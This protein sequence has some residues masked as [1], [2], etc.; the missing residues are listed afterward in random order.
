MAEDLL[1]LL[2]SWARQRYVDAA[3][4]GAGGKGCVYVAT[5][6][7]LQRPVALKV[8]SPDLSGDRRERH[9]FKREILT[10][11]H[12]KHPNVVQFY[13]FSDT[14]DVMFYTMELLEGRTLQDVIQTDDLSI[15]EAVELVRQVCSGV[16]AIHGAGLF[17]RDLKPGNVVV[18]D[19]GGV[20]VIDF[21][22]VKQAVDA[23]IT[24]I[25]MRGHVVGTI[26]YQP[27][28]AFGQDG[29]TARSDV[30]QLG[31]ILYEAL[32]GC[33][34]LES[35]LVSDI[36]AGEAQRRV[37]P[38]STVCAGVDG[39]LDD[40][41]MQCL[42]PAA[43]ARPADAEALGTGLA[44]WLR[45]QGLGP[46]RTQDVVPE[47]Q[48]STTVQVRRPRR[49][50]WRSRMSAL[51]AALTMILVGVLGARFIRSRTHRQTTTPTAAATSSPAPTGVFHTRYAEA[52]ASFATGD[53]TGL[54][55]AVAELRRQADGTSR[56]QAAEFAGIASAVL[57]GAP[58]TALICGGRLT[59]DRFPDFAVRPDAFERVTL[60]GLATV[61]QRPSSAAFGRTAAAVAALTAPPDQRLPAVVVAM[62]EFLA[63]FAARDEP[64]G[65]SGSAA[66]DDTVRRGLVA[67]AFHDGLFALADEAFV[68]FAADEVGLVAAAELVRFLSDQLAG[69]WQADDYRRRC[70]SCWQSWL[71]RLASRQPATE[72]TVR[73]YGDLVVRL[74]G[75]TATPLDG[76]PSA[77]LP[78]TAYPSNFQSPA[79]ADDEPLVRGVAIFTRAYRTFALRE[80]ARE[81]MAADFSSA[82]RLLRRYLC[83]GPA[84]GRR[85]EAAAYLYLGRSLCCLGTVVVPSSFERMQ[86]M[87]GLHVASLDET[88][89]LRAGL[90]ALQRAADTAMRAG[91][92]RLAR[93]AEFHLAC[94]LW[95]IQGRSVDGYRGFQ[96]LVDLEA[97][98]PLLRR[99]LTDAAAVFTATPP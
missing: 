24:A 52:S 38:P 96:R 35:F 28:E 3:L 12:L 92:E 68:R 30:Y 33:H 55:R 76:L 97:E 94:W 65:R 51:T 71:D 14:D 8:I 89:T 49:S 50:R 60:Y 13:D 62:Q 82:V 72:A 56:V 64:S 98:R 73:L 48:P 2:P 16:G 88:D 77:C 37:P 39:Q 29:Y 15:A 7:Q 18:T 41:V 42:Q 84:D 80:G 40:L 67:A 44:K 36:I 45:S 63:P 4:L 70:L 34:P 10:V 69:A 87:Q 75:A 79:A 22:A 74:A 1:E 17:H 53:G 6:T 46:A 25:T 47:T 26:L 9:R 85:H 81:A 27:P 66:A 59:I 11:A 32:T 93:R 91:D 43:E 78:S 86:M 54:T 20:K 21:G 90:G 31:L 19:D 95:R 58:A 61:R 83:D 5:D 57:D 99:Y 23:N